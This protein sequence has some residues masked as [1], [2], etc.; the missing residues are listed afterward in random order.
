MKGVLKKNSK[1][2]L[3]IVTPL[4]LLFTMILY[5]R[6]FIE[7]S[8]STDYETVGTITKIE[9][10]KDKQN[11]DK[12]NLEIEYE[13]SKGNKTINEYAVYENNEKYKELKDNKVKIKTKI[14]IRTEEGFAEGFLGKRFLYSVIIDI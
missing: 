6:L 9:I 13:D 12:C 1:F 3:L 8:Y 4:L 14:N 5:Y 10:E 2:I 11:L 7:V